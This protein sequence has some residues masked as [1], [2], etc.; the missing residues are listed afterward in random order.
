MFLSF[1]FCFWSPHTHRGK[2]FAPERLNTPYVHRLASHYLLPSAKQCGFIGLQR[3]RWLLLGDTFEFMF[4]NQQF[5]WYLHTIRYGCSYGDL[6][7]KCQ[8]CSRGFSFGKCEQHITRDSKQNHRN[9]S[10]KHKQRIS[11]F[12]S[13][14]DCSKSCPQQAKITRL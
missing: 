6:R 9:H 5:Q 14:H 7:E 8:S 1:T 4:Y 10:L 11:Y 13:R 2:H 3:R 12:P